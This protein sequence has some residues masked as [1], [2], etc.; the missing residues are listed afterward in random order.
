MKFPPRYFILPT[1]AATAISREPFGDGAKNAEEFLS[2]KE[3]EHLLKEERRKALINELNAWFV[4]FEEALP[5]KTKMIIVA[6][7][8]LEKQEMLKSQSTGE[9]K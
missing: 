8:M 5:D 3:H 6:N 9:E 2:V 7:A 1:Q 4:A